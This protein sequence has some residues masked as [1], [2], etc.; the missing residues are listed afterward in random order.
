MSRKGPEKSATLYKVGTKK[1]GN[2]NNIWV[3]KQNKNGINKWVLFRKSSKKLSK[4]SSKESL[5][6]TDKGFSDFTK[7]DYSVFDIIYQYKST[8]ELIMNTSLEYKINVTDKNASNAI[9]DVTYEKITNSKKK[10][11]TS[12]CL[13]GKLNKNTFMWSDTMRQT[14]LDNTF[15]NYTK[16]FKSKKLINSLKKLFLHPQITFP[17]KYRQIIPYFISFIFDPRSANI[18]RFTGDDY[19]KDY[20]YIF[21]K[22]SIDIPYWNEMTQHI[23]DNLVQMKGGGNIETITIE[24]MKDDIISH[25]NKLI[26]EINI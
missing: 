12:M 7:Y 9:T 8:Y 24:E 20:T 6:K 2:D 18:I 14:L 25:K 15:N 3:V 21:I 10:I 5:K 22:M 11:K 23:H 13:F 19:T 4:R 17:E 26:K 16:D 1:T